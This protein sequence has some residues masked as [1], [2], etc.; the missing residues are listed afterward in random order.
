[1]VLDVLMNGHYDD[2]GTS[3][4]E[5]WIVQKFGGTSIGKFAVNVVEDIVRCGLS[6]LALE[7]CANMYLHLPVPACRT[8]A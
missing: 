1:M 7:E 5:K 4:E 2:A 6:A 8:I 3:E